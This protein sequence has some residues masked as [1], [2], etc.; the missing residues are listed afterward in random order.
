MK[1]LDKFRVRVH[2]LVRNKDGVHEDGKN[3]TMKGDVSY[4]PG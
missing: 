2:D 1:L 4:L 3:E